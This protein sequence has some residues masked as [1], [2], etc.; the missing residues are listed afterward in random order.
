MF[1]EGSDR[2][3]QQKYEQILIFSLRRILNAEET[4]EMYITNRMSSW[5]INSAWLQPEYGKPVPNADEDQEAN[6]DE[7][8]SRS[9]C[10]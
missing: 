6:L 2:Q 8:S 9:F 3:L 7:S 4:L 10:E 5:L 1:S